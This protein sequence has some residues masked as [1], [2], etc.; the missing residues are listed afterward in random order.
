LW[1]RSFG[2]GS[3]Q[4]LT[5]T[6]GAMYPFWSPDNRQIGFFADGKLKS[7]D[8]SAGAIRIICDARGSGGGT[9][10]RSGTIVFFDGDDRSGLKKVAAAGGSSKSAIDLKS[11]NGLW[12]SF[13]PNDDHF[14]FFV[15]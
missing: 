14:L 3:A 2:A 4:Q 8:L 11:S 9:W 12:P 10:N 6:D 1:I 13:L 15:T 5:G 7:V